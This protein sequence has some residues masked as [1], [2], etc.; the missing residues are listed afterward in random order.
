MSE[1]VKQEGEFKIKK[2]SKPKNL[3]KKEEVTKVEIPKTPIDGQGKVAPE[4]T[5]VEKKKMPFKHKRQM[6]AMLLSKNP[7][8]VATAKK[9]LKKYGKPKKK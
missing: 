3:G 6:I 1:E 7:E 8:T 9:W 4:V 2:P 5:K